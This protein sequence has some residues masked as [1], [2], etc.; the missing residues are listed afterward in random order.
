MV[1]EMENKTTGSH[2]LAKWQLIESLHDISDLEIFN[3]V[4][5]H[6]SEAEALEA[7]TAKQITDLQARK[8]RFKDRAR[9]LRELVNVAFDKFNIHKLETPSGTCSKVTRRASK[10]IVADEGALLVDYPDLYTQ[11]PSKLDKTA[12]KK[13]LMEGAKIDGVELSDSTS[14]QIRK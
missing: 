5:Y 11:Q 8:D 13:L 6:I 12:L 7:A 3:N 2:Y 1:N 9:Q 10:L 4:I 14:I